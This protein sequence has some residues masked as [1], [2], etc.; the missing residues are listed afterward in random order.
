MIKVSYCDMPSDRPLDLPA[1]DR[2]AG[3][4]TI[5]FLFAGES[6]LRALNVSVIPIQAYDLLGSSQKVSIVATVVSFCVLSTT[7]LLPYIFR[8]LRRRWVYSIG[9]GLVMGAALIFAAN[10]VAGQVVATYFRNVG[11]S[12]LNITLALYIMDNIAKTELTR[13]EPLRMTIATASW[14][15]GPALGTWL[16]ARYGSVVPQIAVVVAGVLLMIGFWGVRLRDPEVL[17]P[18]TMEGFNPLANVVQFLQQPRLRLAWAVAFGRSCFWSALFIYGPLLMI[19]G[20]LPI[21]TAG[22]IISASQLTLPLSYFHGQ[23]ARRFGVRKVIALCFAFM[24]VFA[25][26]TG[27]LGTLHVWAAIVC[28][29]IA[30]VCASGLDGVGGVT[31]YRA[32]RP[33]ERQRMTSV[34]RTF[35][36][37]SELLPGFLFMF[38]LLW[39]DVGIVFI[40][41]AVLSGFLAAVTWKYLPKSM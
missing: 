10:L 9:I 3:A 8:S 4:W 31:F 6:L 20:G 16:Y 19:E 37:C 27:L 36:E 15:L 34:Y 23:L 18:G 24:A 32:V 17:A 30:A 13:V 33:R 39:F 28:L 25:F 22:F 11:A 14:V 5:S 40:V 21:A 38:L 12:I 29:L 41:I 35:F 2:K 7:L 1:T 26:L